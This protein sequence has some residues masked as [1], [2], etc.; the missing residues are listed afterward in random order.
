MHSY[1][2]QSQ[3]GVF[4]RREMIGELTAAE[5]QSVI[6]STLAGTGVSFDQEIIKNISS[7]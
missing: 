3:Y 5:T 1:I 6:A 4:R 7:G 2:V